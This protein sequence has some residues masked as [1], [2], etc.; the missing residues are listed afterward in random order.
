MKLKEKA[1]PYKNVQ[2]STMTRPLSEVVSYSTIDDYELSLLIKRS[3]I[4]ST[5]ITDSPTCPTKQGRLSKNSKSKNNR[6]ER[7]QIWL[8]LIV[9]ARCEAQ[10]SG[11]R[12]FVMVGCI[13]IDG[14]D[15]VC[16]WTAQWSIPLILPCVSKRR[17]DRCAY[18]ELVC[19]LMWGGELV[20]SG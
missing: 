5:E 18:K 20:V 7:G 1:I 8:H 17:S 3:I 15:G 6:T 2:R 13:Q 4:I 10:I 11:L 19:L 16:R 12:G 14:F 9:I